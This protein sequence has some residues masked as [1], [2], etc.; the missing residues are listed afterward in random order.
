MPV[1]FLGLGSNID[2][3]HNIPRILDALLA[4]APTIDISRI[5][6]T[7]PVGLTDGGGDFLNVVVRLISDLPASALKARL[8]DIEIALGRDRSHPHSKK[9]SRPAD[10][11]ILLALPAARSVAAAADL[12]DEPYTLPL[13]IE[14]L[15]VHGQASADIGLPELPAG[16][17]LLLNRLPIGALPATLDAGPLS[18]TVNKVHYSYDTV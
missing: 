3:V 1:Y 17:R 15:H 13:L 8:T 16:Q 14:L 12:P 4:L 10:I 11:D 7:A 5:I 6:R 18:H 9:L 2:P